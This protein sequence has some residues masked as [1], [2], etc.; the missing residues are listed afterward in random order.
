MGSISPS[1]VG[2]LLRS[3]TQINSSSLLLIPTTP[4]QFVMSLHEEEAAMHDPEHLRRVDVSSVSLI[5]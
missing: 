4:D 1:H 5:G 3:S 2:T